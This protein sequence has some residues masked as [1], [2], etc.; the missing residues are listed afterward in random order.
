MYMATARRADT[1]GWGMRMWES[2]W[3]GPSVH[4]Q[5]CQDT[6]LM[7]QFDSFG[8]LPFRFFGA[9]LGARL[10]TCRNN[11]AKNKH[12]TDSLIRKVLHEGI[13]G[14][15]VAGGVDAE[16]NAEDNAEGDADNSEPGAHDAINNVMFCACLDE[17]AFR[18]QPHDL[19]DLE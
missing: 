16:D 18:R 5:L 1:L 2:Q 7:L 4:A 13:V 8:G 14:P 19:T 3:I 15:N 12:L 11:A 6:S 17:W 10:C 9:M